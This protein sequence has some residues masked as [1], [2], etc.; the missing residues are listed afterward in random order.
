MQKQKGYGC[1]CKK[2]ASS[3]KAIRMMKQNADIY[4]LRMVKH[5]ADEMPSLAIKLT[6]LAH[7]Y[8]WLKCRAGLFESTLH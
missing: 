7:M 5:S 8:F 4:G 6:E 3:D 1:E 2:D